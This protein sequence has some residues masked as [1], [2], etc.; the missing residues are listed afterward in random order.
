MHIG[1]VKCHQ[2]AARGL[3]DAAVVSKHEAGGLMEKDLGAGFLC[4]AQSTKTTFEHT[5]SSYSLS[6]YDTKSCSLIKKK[7]STGVNTL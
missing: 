1:E 4:W 2:S 6:C 7:T 5:F 3:K